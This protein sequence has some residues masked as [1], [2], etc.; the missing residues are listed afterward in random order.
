LER[1]LMPSRRPRAALLSGLTVVLS[2]AT[3]A[4]VAPTAHGSLIAVSNEASHSVT[5]I[6]ASTLRIVRTVPLPQRPRGIQF[7]PDG[8]RI[9]VALSDPQT[10]VQSSGDGIAA[11]DLAANRIIAPTRMG[12]RHP[13]PISLRAG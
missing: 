13:Q 5:L 6:D 10:Q 9:F 12:A 2:S 3:A 11:F 1:P 7:T 4:Q 8:K